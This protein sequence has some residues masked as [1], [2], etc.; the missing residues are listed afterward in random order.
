MDKKTAT[1]MKWGALLHKVLD[2]SRTRNRSSSMETQEQ[3]EKPKTKWDNYTATRRTDKSKK[4]SYRRGPAPV[5]E[6]NLK[7]EKRETVNGTIDSDVDEIIGMEEEGSVMGTP[8]KRRMA[9]HQSSGTISEDSEK[10]TRIASCK[11]LLIYFSKIGK[12]Y[13]EH[14]EIDLNFLSA[15]MECG[16]DINISDKHGQTVL[17]EVARAWHTD[18]ARFVCENGGDVNKP[19]EYGRTPLHVASIVNYPEMVELL[20]ML[21][22]M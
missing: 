17:H 15:L 22:G 8:V 9:G 14:D 11:A 6:V 4:L 16:A 19:D 10:G 1:R 5:E 13:D 7:S 20:I 12:S 18:V 2:T 21:G 3:D